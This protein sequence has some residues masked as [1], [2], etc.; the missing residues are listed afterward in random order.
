MINL[1]K[2]K[3]LCKEKEKKNIFR[4]FDQKQIDRN[5]N[6]SMQKRSEY[7]ATRFS[8]STERS[9]SCRGD[10]IDPSTAL[11]SVASLYPT[12]RVC[13]PGTTGGRAQVSNNAQIGLKSNQ[14]MHQ[15]PMLND[16]RRN[17]I[18]DSYYVITC[19]LFSD[20]FSKRMEIKK[21]IYW[22]KKTG[23]ASWIQ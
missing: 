1:K 13:W 17:F 20:P 10:Y 3:S 9:F 18:I 14:R 16:M 6:P 22:K 8:W 7:G 23:R 5:Q 11:E 4:Y 2:W 21:Y 19:P 15:A 12:S